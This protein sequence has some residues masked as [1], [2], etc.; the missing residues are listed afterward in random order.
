M[1]IYENTAIGNFIYMM[2]YMQGR[3]AQQHPKN[4]VVFASNLFQQTPLDSSFADYFCKV[5]DFSVLIEFKRS[6]NHD[7]KEMI[8]R[9]RLVYALNSRRELEPISKLGHWLAMVG[10]DNDGNDRDQLTP[11]I[12]QVGAG[13]S[14]YSY[15][16]SFLSKAIKDQ[17]IGGLRIGLPSSEMS[18][19]LDFVKSVN[20]SSRSSGGAVFVASVTKNGELKYAALPDIQSLFLTKEKVLELINQKSIA[21]EKVLERDISKD[22]SRDHGLGM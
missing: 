13:H 20:Q 1:N 3:M 19:Y 2:G 8:K 9:N 11:Y 7:S 4:E 14:F 6:Q 12:A 17:Y 18:E 16:A 5:S 21:T 22:R 15:I 10:K